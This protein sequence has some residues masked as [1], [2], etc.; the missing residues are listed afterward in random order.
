MLGDG[1]SGV[2]PCITIG[3]RRISRADAPLMIAEVSANHNG[4]I[5][6]AFEILEACAAAGAEAVK[7]QTYTADTMT[8]QSERPEFQITGGLW[9]GYSLYD[10]Y[11]EAATPWD[12]HPAL[13]A[14]ARDLGL[15]VFST[16][17]D[18]TAVDFLE[19]LGAP[20]YKIA[21]FELV[22]H[23]LIRKV[24]ATGKPMIMSTGMADLEEISEAVQVAR[25]AGCMELA[26]L[27]CVSGYPT[28]MHDANIQTMPDLAARFGAVAGFSDHTLGTA[29]SV[30]AV[31]LGAR[32]IEKH[33]TLRRADGGPD[34]AFSLEPDELAQLV[35]DCRNAFEAV[36]QV[37]Y[38][39][40]NSEMNNLVFRRSLFA[41]ADI[42]AGERLTAQNVRCIRPGYGLPPR[43]LPIVLGRTARTNIA[44]GTPLDWSLLS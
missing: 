13:F 29:A 4:R 14:K 5:E 36:G 37:R 42:R 33:V 8:I 6:R 34:A 24:A 9:D 11:Q 41:V 23:M 21:S 30:A 27:H 17:F 35:R 18:E 7:L 44:R 32:V 22:D 31:A 15:I 28:P 25:Q 40:K 19:E 20:L 12:W 3:D 39:R 26:L 38:D 10:L 43:D 2:E 16:P 1:N